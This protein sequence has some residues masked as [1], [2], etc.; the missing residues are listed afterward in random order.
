MNTIL[1]DAL[2]NWLVIFLSL[3]G[4]T[5][6]SSIVG[7]LV[8]SV[9]NSAKKHRDFAKQVADEIEKRD[10]LIKK[11]VQALLRNDLYELYYRCV[12][13]K[14]ATINEKNNFENL[15]TQYH[16]LGKNGVMDSLN[17]E[18]MKLPSVRPTTKKQKLN[19]DK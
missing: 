6:I 15:Y 9:V 4:S 12:E 7:L 10:E 16:A 11:G 1:S 19:E 2:P 18:F 3:G 8:T 5:L 13:K 17:E 14:Y